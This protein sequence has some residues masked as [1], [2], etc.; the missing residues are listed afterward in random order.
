MYVPNNRVSKYMKQNLPKLKGE[1]DKST[2]KVGDFKN[3]SLRDRSCFKSFV[4][5]CLKQWET[6]EY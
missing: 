2:I 3:S 5:R 6:F 4:K 1:G